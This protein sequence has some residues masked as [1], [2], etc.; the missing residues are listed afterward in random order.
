[1]SDEQLYAAIRTAVRTDPPPVPDMVAGG[2]AR[3]RSL[4]RRRGVIGGAAV[5]AVVCVSGVVVGVVA[6]VDEPDRTETATATD[7]GPCRSDVRDD[8]IP[9]WARVGFSDPEPVVPHVMGERGEIV[10]ILFGRTL[11][12]PPSQEVN[13]KILWVAQTVDFGGTLEIDA[14]RAGTTT[15]VSREVPGGPGP[16]TIDLP[17][18]GCWHLELRW[19]DGADQHDS[20]DLEYVRP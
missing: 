8:V 18:P 19:G 6:G 5:A 20:M 2:L 12:S 17:E 9:P 1:M 15:H 13:N 14:V 3:G 7:P 4:R 10:A 16:S 11:H